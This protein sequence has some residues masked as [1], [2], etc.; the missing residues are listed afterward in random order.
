[1]Q[2]LRSFSVSAGFAQPR[3]VGL[4]LDPGLVPIR[5][6]EKWRLRM[7]RMIERKHRLRCFL[8]ERLFRCAE[9]PCGANRDLA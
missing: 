5:G 1:M 3:I 2:L 7:M 4:H 9:L 8:K 6:S